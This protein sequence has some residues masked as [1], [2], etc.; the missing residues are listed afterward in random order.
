MR[1]LEILVYKKRTVKK[2]NFVFEGLLRI[3]DKPKYSPTLA[4]THLQDTQNQ[5]CKMGLIFL[6]HF[7]T[8]STYNWTQYAYGRNVIEGRTHNIGIAASGAGR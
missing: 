6:P 4:Q 1:L 7:R 5:S 2:V 8:H 3:P